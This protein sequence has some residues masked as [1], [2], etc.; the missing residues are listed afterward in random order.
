MKRPILLI[1]M[2]LSAAACSKKTAANYPHCLKLR[3]GMTKEELMKVMGPP[4]ETMP[5]VEGKSLPHLQGRTAYEW[6]NPASMPGPNHVSVVDETG[7]V[8]S[9][10]CS[11]SVIS[12]SVFVEPPAPSTAA[13]QA[14]KPAT[15]RMA[16]PA[17][18]RG[19]VGT[20][21]PGQALT[22]E[23]TR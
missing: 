1:I 17:A 9:V 2:I 19:A 23:E 13:V 18:P 3:L 7:K 12:A 8:T 14:V 6:A 20:G 11:D 22:G 16:A 21:A 15:A 5:Y 10:R 4:D